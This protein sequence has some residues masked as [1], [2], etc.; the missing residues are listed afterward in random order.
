L[1]TSIPLLALAW[2]MSQPVATSVLIGARSIAQADQAVEAA[3]LQMSATSRAELS[4]S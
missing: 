2:V 3:A 1:G 4:A